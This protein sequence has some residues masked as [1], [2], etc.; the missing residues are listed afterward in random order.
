MI[1]AAWISSCLLSSSPNVE[2]SRLSS[3]PGCASCSTVK[4]WKVGMPGTKSPSPGIEFSVLRHGWNHSI[5]FPSFILTPLFTK[6]DFLLSIMMQKSTG[7][8]FDAAL[9]HAFGT[10]FSDQVRHPFT[11]PINHN[12]EAITRLEPQPRS[13]KVSFQRINATRLWSIYPRKISSLLHTGPGP[14]VPLFS[15]MAY[16]TAALLSSKS[17]T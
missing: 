13:V 2:V 8:T 14:C 4:R 3:E 17:R 11:D 9:R 7:R 10:A 15:A 1:N 12:L 6:L 5:Q 16:P